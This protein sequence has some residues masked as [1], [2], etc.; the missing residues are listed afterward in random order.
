M[1][2]SLS[3]SLFLSLAL[4]TALPQ[5]INLPAI[6]NWLQF[7]AHNPGTDDDN[8][9]QTQRFVL[10]YLQSEMRNSGDLGSKP[11]EK[12]GLAAMYVG[13]ASHNFCSHMI[14]P[15]RWFCFT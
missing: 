8:D 2:P 13:R 4:R 5:I 9:L 7:N 15:S 1:M 10:S 14:D 3:L 6:P 12:P 11:S